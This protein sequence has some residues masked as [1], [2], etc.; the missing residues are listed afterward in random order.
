MKLNGMAAAV[1]AAALLAPVALAGPVNVNTADAQTIAKELN[2]I[3]L[4]KAQAI[5]AH[6]EKNGPFKTAEDLA[7]VQGVG[8]KTVERIRADL[9]FEAAKPGG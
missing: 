9:R 1:L 7:K 5:V 8:L 6:R 4:S 2:G 3:G